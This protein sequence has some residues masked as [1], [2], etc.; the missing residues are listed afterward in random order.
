MKRVVL[1]FAVVALL[2]L[3]VTAQTGSTTTTGQEGTGSSS[4]NQGSTQ[5]TQTTTPGTT[6][7]TGTSS[8]QEER[9]NPDMGTTAPGSGLTLS[10]TVVSWNDQELVV[11][12]TTGIEH[13][14]L[15][16]DTQ[17]PSSFTVGEQVAVDYVRSSQNGVMIARQVRPG[18]VGSSTTTTVG[19]SQ[20]EQDVEEGMDELG[21][22]AD[23]VGA[24]LSRIDDA[25]EE[26]IEEAVG[27][28]ID[29]DGAIGNAGQTAALDD[30]DDATTLPAT[31]G[32]G[33]LAALLGL[34]ALGVAAV[35]RRV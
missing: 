12:T 10:G 25:A 5:G 16:Q 30:A 23:E 2:A 24:D 14:V 8:V 26:E 15:Q 1:S 3:P 29:N 27:G 28:S 20:L 22:T 11:R 4:L 21:D 18:G 9:T 7:Q 34:L 31:G 33:P 19:E 32:K 13:I 6:G 17:R 35:L